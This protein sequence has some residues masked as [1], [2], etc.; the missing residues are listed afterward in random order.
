MAT[1]LLQ[2]GQLDFCQGGAACVPVVK[3]IQEIFDLQMTL[4]L[5]DRWEGGLMLSSFVKNDI[6][7]RAR[8]RNKN[9]PVKSMY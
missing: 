6:H 8:H 2:I 5:N 3:K 4:Y 7:I 9:D 1:Y